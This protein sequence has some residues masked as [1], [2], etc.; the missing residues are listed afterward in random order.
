MTW[1]RLTKHRRAAQLRHK[2]NQN[3]YQYY[4]LDAP[5]ISDAEYDELKRQLIAIEERFP[6]LVTP[7]SPTQRVGGMPKQGVATIPHEIPMLSIQSI[8]SAKDFRHFYESR[9]RELGKTD[10]RLVACRSEFVTAD[11]AGGVRVFPV[12]RLGVGGVCVDVASEFAS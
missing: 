8:W 10:C 6:K 11:A 12:D 2:I 1:H 3:D 9:C 7:D 4:A 5:L